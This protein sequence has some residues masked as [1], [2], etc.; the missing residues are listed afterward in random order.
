MKALFVVSPTVDELMRA[1]LRDALSA[2]DPASHGIYEIQPGEE[3]SEVVAR[4]MAEEDVERAVA[5]GGDGTV[6]AVAH[7]L[8]DSPRPLGIVPAGTGNLVARELGIP[9]DVRTAVALVAGPHRL[10]RIDTMRVNGRTFLLNAG[11][12]VNAKTADNTPRLGKSLFGRTAYV[13]TAVLE[14]LQAKSVRLEIEVDGTA[15]TYEATDVLISNCGGLARVL[16][17]NGPIIEMDDGQVDVCVI[18]MKNPLE[19]PLYY[20]GKTLFPDHE[21]RIVHDLP[22][23]CTV[24]IRS[25]TPIAVQAD[26]D[27]VGTTPVT[28]NVYPSALSVIVP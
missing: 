15:H 23:R 7:A 5:V 25:D 28:I 2:H 24:T 22:A 26:G 10:R 20:L 6:S 12:G 8:A 3:I 4:R 14:V 27:V 9:L 11:V 16:H 13:G 19:Y 1:A 18:C 17:P 21:T